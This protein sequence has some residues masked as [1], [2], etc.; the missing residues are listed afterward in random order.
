MYQA[1]WLD[2]PEFSLSPTICT[3]RTLPVTASVA[4]GFLETLFSTL[5]YILRITRD[6]TTMRHTNAHLPCLVMR[7]LQQRFDGR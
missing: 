6:A 2:A 5:R 3:I 4:P 1:A 7:W